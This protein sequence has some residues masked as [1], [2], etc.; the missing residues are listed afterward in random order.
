MPPSPL[1]SF[2]VVRSLNFACNT[3]AIAQDRDGNGII[4][5]DELKLALSE[6]QREHT[7][8]QVVAMMRM[9]SEGDD[10]NGDGELDFGEFCNIV[11]V[12]NAEKLKGKLKRRPSP[13]VAKSASVL[14]LGAISAMQNKADKSKTK[15]FVSAEEKAAKAEAEAEKQARGMEEWSKWIGKIG[16][17]PIVLSALKISFKDGEQAAF[18]SMKNLT[19]E[20]VRARLGEAEL[21]GLTDVIMAGVKGLADQAAPSGSALNDK[22]KKTGKF[23]MACK[24]WSL[25]SLVS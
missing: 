20:E 18:D 16:V 4:D 7:D 25:E 9:G 8:A 1:S 6:V 19:Y 10:G 13:S 12:V 15:A 14:A 24:R 23:M 3:C 22:F 2:S 11:K 5:K 17:A 21:G